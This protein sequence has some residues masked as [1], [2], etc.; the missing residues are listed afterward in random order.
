MLTKKV[1]SK[2][3]KALKKVQTDLQP[4]CR[5]STKYA[6]CKL[7]SSHLVRLA[8]QIRRKAVGTLLG[9]KKNIMELQ[10]YNES[11]FG[12]R[13]HTASR[14]PYF[15]D[16]AY[17][18]AKVS[19]PNAVQSNGQCRLSDMNCS[20]YPQQKKKY[21]RRGEKRCALLGV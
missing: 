8:L 12:P 15:N 3:I 17:T 7:A 11:D 13:Q 20:K 6:V 10:L 5:Q 18:M 9:I 16:A 2:L 21:H 1:I 4:N 19:S 14:E